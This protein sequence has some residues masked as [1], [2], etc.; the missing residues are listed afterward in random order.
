MKKN[1]P[2]RKS[3]VGGTVS[4][5]RKRKAKASSPLAHL[6]S[7]T[8]VKTAAKR[9]A[10]ATVFEAIWRSGAE[11]VE[12]VKEAAHRVGVRLRD[13]TSW[14]QR[15]NAAA[16]DE[17][18]ASID[19]PSQVDPRAVLGNR[20]GQGRPSAWTDVDCQQ[21]PELNVAEHAYF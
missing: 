2:G 3:F 6:G 14:M 16:G 10:F 17:T 20:P 1:K 5:R 9:T 12:A 18:D 13:A 19:S 4:P 8:A 15:L 11:K 7:R 21:R